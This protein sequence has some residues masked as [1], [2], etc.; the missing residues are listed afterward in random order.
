MSR[1]SR[2]FTL[3]GER[4]R[5]PCKQPLLG[6]YGCDGRFTVEVDLVDAEWTRCIPPFSFHISRADTGLRRIAGGGPQG[7]PDAG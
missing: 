4:A 3:G 2:A 7:P 1:V 6:V 5:N